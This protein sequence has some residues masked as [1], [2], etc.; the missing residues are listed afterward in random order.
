LVDNFIN[1][2][3]EELVNSNFYFTKKEI[4]SALLIFTILVAISILGIFAIIGWEGVLEVIEN[5]SPAEKL[6]E[7]WIDDRFDVLSDL[8]VFFVILIIL[9]IKWLAARQRIYISKEGIYYRAD[10][11]G[12]LRWAYKD[13]QLKWCDIQTVELVS[14]R[15]F[16]QKVQRTVNIV[17]G[18]KEQKIVPGFWKSKEA[19][20]KDKKWW[21]I[22][23]HL[24]NENSMEGLLDSIIYKKMKEAGVSINLTEVEDHS[25]SGFALEKHPRTIAFM[26]GL[27]VLG[28]YIFIDGLAVPEA[29]PSLPGIYNIVWV[30]LALVLVIFLINWLK[31]G[32][33][34]WGVSIGLGFLFLLVAYPSFYIV[35]LRIN[36]LTDAEG[37]APYRYRVEQGIRLVP[38]RIDLPVI[39]YF[40][41]SEFWNQYLTGKIIEIELRHGGLGIW[42]F[43]LEKVQDAIRDFNN[44]GARKAQPEN[45]MI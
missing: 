22:K 7:K 38:E 1:E 2:N 30:S 42:Q 32:K 3:A 36:M 10:L 18:A 31:S 21:P 28:L 26:W 14:S 27:A 4:L 15:I 37:L 9:V 11:P 44:N 19:H 34:P 41:Y 43:N 17:S 5:Y 8:I 35:T 13:W 20:G 25:T 16:Q 23:W 33:V 12:V 6:S 29:Y 24:K 40:D 39:T 45:K